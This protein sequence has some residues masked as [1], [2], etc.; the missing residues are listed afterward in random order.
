ME[1][2]LAFC[3]E[4]DIGANVV[5]RPMSEVNECLGELETLKHAARF[6]LTNEIPPSPPT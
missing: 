2:M 6:V 3:A 5:T 4:H 1:Q